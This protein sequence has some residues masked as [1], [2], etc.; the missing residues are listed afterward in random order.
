LNSLLASSFTDDQ[1][2]GDRGDSVHNML[3]ALQHFAGEWVTATKGCLNFYDILLTHY[4]IDSA[5]R[6]MKVGPCYR[7]FG[8]PSI[9]WPCRTA[10]TTRSSIVT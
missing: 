5:F 1:N 6:S 3:V 2:D 8:S 10:A 7:I 9:G 4:V